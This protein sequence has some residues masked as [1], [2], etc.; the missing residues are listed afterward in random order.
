MDKMEILQGI[1]QEN[2]EWF[3]NNDPFVDSETNMA[4]LWDGFK[5]WCVQNCLE[6]FNDLEE[7]VVDRLVDQNYSNWKDKQIV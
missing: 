3:W 5:V 6:I 4:K 1:I 7:S 2:I